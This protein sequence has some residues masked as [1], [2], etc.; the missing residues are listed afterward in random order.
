MTWNRLALAG[1]FVAAFALAACGDDEP[2]D[3]AD[4]AAVV[5]D[6]EPAME[7]EAPAMESEAPAMEAEAPGE[8]AGDPAVGQVALLSLF[9]L[10]GNWAPDAASCTANENVVEIGATTLSTPED[11]CDITSTESADGSL[12]LILACYGGASETWTVTPAS[13]AR[14]A[15]AITIADTADTTSLVRCAN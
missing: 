6:E 14:P 10:T 1:A 8:V 3:A 13:D 7:A 4:D 11:S 9:D 15:D 12:E 2:D 5:V